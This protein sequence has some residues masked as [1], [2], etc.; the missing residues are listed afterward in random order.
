MFCEVVFKTV[1]RESNVYEARWTPALSKKLAGKQGETAETKEYDR[2]EVGIFKSIEHTLLLVGHAPVELS[3]LLFCFLENKKGNVL[4]L[5]LSGKRYPE[6]AIAILDRNSVN[7][8]QTF[9]LKEKR[10]I[11]LIVIYKQQ[12]CGNVVVTNSLCYTVIEKS[13]NTFTHFFHRAWGV[14]SRG[15]LFENPSLTCCAYIR[16][17]L[18]KVG[19]LLR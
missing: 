4:L 9:F 3:F 13:N 6:V 10:D 17:C 7:F 14:Y 18:F 5:H 11:D 19:R 8:L 16:G 15:H 12:G 2:F 1:I